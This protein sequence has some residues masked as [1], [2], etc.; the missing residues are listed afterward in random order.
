MRGLRWVVV[1]LGLL[2]AAQQAQAARQPDPGRAAHGT[3]RFEERS[4]DGSNNN[5][6]HPSRGQAGTPYRRVAPPRYADGVQAQ[7]AG[8][9]PR[10]V[11]NR[12]F[13]DLGQN[14]FSERGVTQWAWTWGQFIDHTFGLA[15]DGGERA[16]IGFDAS[17]PL[18]RFRNDLGAISF[19]R[20]SAAPGTGTSAANPRG[21]T[22]TVSSY[23]DGWPVYGGTPTRLEWLR[24]GPV[25][26]TLRNNGPRM[27]LEPGGFLPH[28]T[29]RGNAAAAPTMAVDGQLMSHPQDRVVAGD[30]RANE[31]IALTAVHTLF[32][33][34]HNRIVDA[35]PARLPD[36]LRFQIAR[37]VIGAQQQ[38]I[39]YN[40]FLPSVGVRVG[41]Y[42]G[43]RPNVDATLGNEFATVGFRAHSMIHGEF[44]LTA[45][46]AD[47][48]AQRLAALRAMGVEIEAG[49]PGELELVV[50]LNSAFFNPDLVP[51][52]GLGPVLAGLSAE[53]QYAN[54]EQ[55]DDA[56]RSVLFQV[57]GP[58]APDPAA[59]FESPSAEGCFQ[60][61]VDL[62]ALDIQRGRDH[63]MP[64][65]NAL[66]HALGLAP[67][68]SF[69]QI[70]GERSE[71]LDGISIDDPTSVDFLALA[72]RG[73]VPVALDSPDRQESA[74]RGLRRTTLAAR[75]K[76]IYGSVDNVEAFVGMVAERHVPGTELGP[77]Q[78]ALWTR[79]FRAL[80]DGDRF[81][82][83]N[84][85]ALRQIRR[86]YGIDFR[87][88]LA[89]LIA[90]DA[91]GS[92]GSLPRNV[93]LPGAV[94]PDRGRP[95]RP[96]RRPPRA[97]GRPSRSPR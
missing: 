78:L 84:D 67:A 51:A 49:E 24:E 54:D 38:F 10:Y 28:A 88:T 86:R 35:L 59:C 57:P 20:D 92:A 89:Q 18:E 13:N 58:G 2:A 53:A 39:T 26:G 9:S 55:M 40:E 16:P 81:F 48:S 77:L 36:E 34:E 37:R 50:S 83:A 74:V 97:P 41:P 82:Y 29:R 66:R 5:R 56:L 72:G 91:G 87:T 7:A 32:A 76:A 3:L 6:A 80:R 62:G 14:L 90:R 21:Q 96:D 23:I 94:A 64:T 12:V 52:I 75:L 8:P 43:Y 46:A 61:V 1:G 30:V 11:S 60:G 71:S 93:F 22:N 25:D 19:K 69:T 45:N 44:E 65:Y 17:D 68:R 73:G 4:L 47:F 15:A 27:L 70:T 85:P 79:Q 31:N 42:R 95:G 33:R 63:G